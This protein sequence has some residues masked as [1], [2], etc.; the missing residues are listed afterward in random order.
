[1]KADRFIGDELERRL[2]DYLRRLQR[3][4]DRVRAFFRVPTTRYAA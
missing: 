2:C 1:L 3:Q 4:P